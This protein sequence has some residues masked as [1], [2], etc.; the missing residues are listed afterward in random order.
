LTPPQNLICVAG[1]ALGAPAESS[2]ALTESKH[3]SGEPEFERF[4]ALLSFL[5][6]RFEGRR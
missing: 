2:G 1:I 3:I 6:R 4:V 5:H